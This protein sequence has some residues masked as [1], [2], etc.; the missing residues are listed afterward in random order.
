MARSRITMR[1][2]I[3]GAGPTG[4]GAAYRLKELG[5]NGTTVVLEKN[6]YAGGLASSFVDSEGFTWDI[7]GHVQFSHYKYFDNVMDVAIKNWIYHNRESWVWLMERFVPYPFQNNIQSLPKEA[8]LECL[9]GVIDCYTNNKPGS[10]RSFQEWI[11]SN[12]GSGIAK[13]FMEPYNLK[14]WAYPTKMLNAKWVGDRAALVDLK[15][16]VVNAIDKKNDV[17]WGPNNQF[18]FPEKGGTGE[19]WRNVAKDLIINYNHTIESIDTTQKTIYYN[20]TWHESKLTYD[21][22]INTLPLDWFINNSDLKE[23]LKIVNRLKHSSVY[24]IGIGLEG[25]PKED[26][27]EKCWMYFPEDNCPFYRVTLFSKYSPMNVPSKTNFSLMCEVSESELKRVNVVNL[28]ENV[29]K[30]LKNTKLI[31]PNEKIISTWM[32]REE[33]GYPTPS[34]ERDE[35]LKS[36]Q[37]VLME[38]CI[39]S[40]GRF[41]GWKYEVSNQ[42]HSFMQGVEA[43]D[44]IINGRKEMTYFHPEIVNGR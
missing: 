9:N 13:Y 23:K 1:I 43:V 39:L 17:N 36:V 15:K 16:L 38:N 35:I 10:P 37:P 33:Y 4:L 19:I 29:I 8:F 11:K 18:R 34:L 7:G 44:F 2:V 14:V 6:D 21:Y 27:K 5:Y 40:R 26:L 22:L 32:R 12:H 3:L 31:K 25:T 30:G 41:G 24:I 28:I 42:D 20:T